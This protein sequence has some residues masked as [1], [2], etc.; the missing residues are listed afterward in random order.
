MEVGGEE[1]VFPGDRSQLIDFQ[2]LSKIAIEV[3]PIFAG[4][5]TQRA[6]L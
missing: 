3:S 2:G 5:G 1:M 6:F 4:F